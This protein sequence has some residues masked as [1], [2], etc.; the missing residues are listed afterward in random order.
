MKKNEIKYYDFSSHLFIIATRRTYIKDTFAIDIDDSRHT[1]T[2]LLINM[3]SISVMVM[4]VRPHK[5]EVDVVLML[6]FP[7]H[8]STTT[9]GLAAAARW[10]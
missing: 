5:G 9:A 3:M 4:F 1:Y 6:L 7:I 10:R 8:S 2:G